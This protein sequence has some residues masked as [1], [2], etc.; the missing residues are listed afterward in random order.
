MR[1]K[2]NL[3]GGIALAAVQASGLT[4]GMI[5]AAPAAMAKAEV[6][7]PA[8]APAKATNSPEFVKLAAPLQKSFAELQAMKGK[9][10]DAEIKAAAAAIAPQLATAESAVKTPLDRI[11][12]GQWQQLLGNAIGEYALMQRGLQNMLDSGQLPADKTALVGV[13]LGQ[14]AYQNKDYA[15]ATKALTPVVAANYSDNAAA[16]LLADAYARQGQPAQGLAALKAAVDARRA[17]G[18][19]VP[20]SWFLRA[21]AIAYNAKLP[22]EGT[23]WALRMVATNPTPANWLGAG[24]LVR[25]YGKFG[26]QDS[27]DISRLLFRSGALGGKSKEIEQEYVDY[28]QA[29]DPRRLPGEVVKVG[30]A[31]IAAG[32]LPANDTFVA[33]AMA[34]A[35]GRVAADKASLPAAARQS[36]TSA[37]GVLALATADAYL[38]YGMDAQAEDF[39]KLAIQKGG[40]DKDKAT[41]RLGI[42]QSD[43]GKTAEAKAT[44]GQVTGPHASIAKLWSIYLDTKAGGKAG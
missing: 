27:V 19:E 13:A 18:G 31:G 17:A 44:F 35:R 21:N 33:D 22:N 20:P 4:A 30:E 37:T 40:V 41:L 23:E 12:Y 43:V 8:K 32:A 6:K 24:Q 26:T 15:G 3:I 9:S 2:S 11:I 42:A 16:E 28:M 36:Q 39:Y 5:G 1:G 7:A 25:I 29:A 38:S 14:L 34:Q 10:T